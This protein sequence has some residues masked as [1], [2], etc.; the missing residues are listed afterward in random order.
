[1]ED[2]YVSMYQDYVYP[3]VDALQ[4]LLCDNDINTHSTTG[5][6]PHKVIKTREGNQLLFVKTESCFVL[7]AVFAAC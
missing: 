6:L 4:C 1:M 2:H 7:L 3:E 5:S